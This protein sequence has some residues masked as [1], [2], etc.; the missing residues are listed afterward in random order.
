MFPQKPMES[1]TPAQPRE[2]SRMRECH[3]CLECFE[4]W[5]EKVR[6]H[7]HYTGKYRGATHQKCNLWYAIPHYINIIFHNLNGSSENWEGNLIPDLL[8]SLL[9]IRK[10]H[11]LQPQHCRRRI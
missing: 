6:D 2:F 4:P 3:I 5:D 10:V 11:Q 9:R 8:V 1:L 7:C